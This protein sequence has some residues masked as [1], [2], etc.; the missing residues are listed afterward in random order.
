MHA[1]WKTITLGDFIAMQRGHD[2][3]ASERRLG[4]VPVFGAAGQNG[5]HDTAI[6]KGPGIVI[7]RSGGSFGQVHFCDTDF[8]PHNTGLYITDFKGND[9]YFAYYLL[10]WLDFDS[11]N[12]GSAQPSLNRNFI[13]PIRIRVPS[14][15]EQQRIARVLT[16]L[17]AKIEL[18][19]R[20][21][22]ELEGLAKLLYDC[23]FVQFEFPLS[24]DQ[25]AALGKPKLAGKPYQASG[26]KMI[27]HPE[28]KR[29]IPEGWE[30]ST[31]G[32]TFNT[33]L[34]GT[35]SRKEPIYWNPGEVSWLSS[36]E[37]EQLFV[38]APD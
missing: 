25:A 2:L 11:Y 36:G 31:I 33:H 12:S 13:Y 23:W 8:W 17:S 24:A 1:D 26:G 20:I 9:P 18:N 14:P 30:V 34:G 38:S 5:F 28:L 35:P 32:E 16:V 15:Q 6:A 3:T 19:Q 29:M 10:K 22:A 37:K 7:G 4:T 27:Y 21:N